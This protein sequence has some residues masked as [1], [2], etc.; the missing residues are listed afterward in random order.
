[1]MGCC[2]IRVLESHGLMMLMCRGA[3]MMRYKAAG[4]Q[5]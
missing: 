1:M 4:A 2:R 5:G 3:R